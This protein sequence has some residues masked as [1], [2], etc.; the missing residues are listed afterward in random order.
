MSDRVLNVIASNKPLQIG[1]VSID[2]Y[3]LEGEIRVLSQRGMVTALAMSSPGSSGVTKTPRFFT[4]NRIKPFINKELAVSLKTPILFNPPLGGKPIYGYSAKLL[5]ELCNI[6]LEAADSVVFPVRQTRIVERAN[7]L[8]RGLASVGIIALV[9]E[10]TGY[11]EQRRRDALQEILDKYLLDEARPWVKTFPLEFYE[12]LFRLKKWEWEALPNNKKPQTPS[13]VGRYTNSLIYKRLFSG[14]P[15]ELI[16][17]LQNLNPQNQTGNRRWRHHQWFQEHNGLPVL[18][19]HI[20]N[21]VT[22]MR[23]SSSWSAFERAVKRAFPIR[24]DQEE[25]N[26][27]D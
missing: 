5:P 12:E 13:V 23:A 1:S 25:L 11:Q 8:I 2:C 15:T 10:C 7:A 26:L 17:E 19:Q 4:S 18:K 20:S 27:D 14:F 6:I 9:D 21:I 24:G 22:L 16:E 3:V